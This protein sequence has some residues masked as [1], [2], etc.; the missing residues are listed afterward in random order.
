[1]R[2]SVST[3]FRR[4]E[5]LYQQALDLPAEGRLPFLQ[6]AC[7][8]DRHL[9]DEVATLIQHYDGA[10]SSFLG[11]PVHSIPAA[12]ALPQQ[13]GRYRILSVLGQ[14]GMGVVYRAEQA[15]PRRP[16]A[17]KVLRGG[18]AG[19]D[20]LR[21]FELEAAVLARLKHPGIAQIYEAG[22]FDDGL[23]QRPFFAMEIVDGLPLR[24]FVLQRRLSIP[25]RVDLMACICDAVQ[26]AHQKGIIHRDLKPANILVIDGDHGSENRNRGRS[27]TA[28]LDQQPQNRGPL[29]KILD[30]GVARA[31][32]Q[33][34][35]SAASGTLAGELVGTLAYMSPEQADGRAALLDTRSD[36]YSLGVMLYELLAN[37]LPYDL[38]DRSVA[39][40]ICAIRETEP[41]PLGTLQPSCRGD[42]STI[43]HKALEKDPEH[44]YP[45]AA[46]LAADLRRYLQHEP[47]VARRATAWYQLRKFARR[48]RVLVSAAA[49]V[50]LTLAVA[51]VWTARV[52]LQEREANRRARAINEFLE[53]I[54]ATA[55][56]ATG[57]ADARFVDVLRSA[58]DQAARRFADSP[59]LE[60]EVRGTLASAFSNLSLF[61][62]ALVHAQRSHQLRRETL[63]PSD[64]QTLRAALHTADLLKRA[65]RYDDAR[66]W[67]EEIIV[68][69]PPDKLRAPTALAARRTIALVRSVR[70]ETDAAE[71]EMRD[72]LS[73]AQQECGATHT[74]ALAAIN[75]LAW[76]LESRV[77]RRLSADPQG[78][79]REAAELFRSIL[80]SHIDLH[81][82]S[83][84][85]TLNVMANLAQTLLLSGQYSESGSFASRVLE[86]SQKH[87]GE[88]HAICERARRALI[89]IRFAEG[90][91]EEAASYAVANVESA[92]RR[93]GGKDSAMSLSEMSDALH[94]LDAAGRWQQ[95]EAYARILL[96]FVGGGAGHAGSLAVRYRIY[97]A[98]FLSAQ[99]RS[100]EADDHFAQVLEAGAPDFDLQVFQDMA[101][102]AHLSARGEF[103]AAEQR[104]VAAFQRMATPNVLLVPTMQE[105][106]RLYE[107]WERPDQAAHWRERLR[108]MGAIDH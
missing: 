74:A 87:L 5:E 6:Q 14:G 45:T 4:V 20:A 56:P 65:Q 89:E 36:V 83:S 62:E 97:I 41:V 33:D 18:V 86:L 96:D 23:S 16:V 39:D 55:N 24:A 10:P 53:D 98:R 7:G 54:L 44:R 100:D 82:E 48:N 69:T 81:G 11:Q 38:T 107:A 67:A 13:I 37:R 71:R 92:Q 51:G 91:Y 64:P 78:D 84:Y 17:L 12:S 60:A 66:R 104:L 85:A 101:Y 77:L 29:P 95:G 70:G 47:I 28:F 26:H 15:N 63:G 80:P 2:R 49:L 40:V 43:V 59:E 19:R 30:F 3:S 90:E 79:S 52:M 106:L 57:R 46:G 9:L 75:D 76:L 103:D 25:Q 72:V 94:V 27:S 99:R 93:S 31:T 22:T 58:A 108:S 35:N 42:L 21:R 1:M 32:D 61:D 102:G 50:L 73:A 34:D 68:R 105:L 8:G 88:D